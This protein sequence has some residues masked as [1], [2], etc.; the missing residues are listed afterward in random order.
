MRV[1]LAVN[2]RTPEHKGGDRVN[3]VRPATFIQQ[4]AEMPLGVHFSSHKFLDSQ[5]LYG[6]NNMRTIQYVMGTMI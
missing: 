4:K 3:T 5:E 2:E 1:L 6:S